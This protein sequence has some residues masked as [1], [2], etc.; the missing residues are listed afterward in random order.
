MRHS[1]RLSLGSIGMAALMLGVILSGCGASSITTVRQG[2]AVSTATATADI[3]F[4]TATTDPALVEMPGCPPVELGPVQSQYITVG[5][6]KVSI[7]HRYT[8]LD[9]PEEL[10]PNSEPNAPYRV[11][12]TASE[13]EQAGAFHPN[14]PVNPS[15][16]TG[17]V[18]QVCNQTG[19]SHTVTSLSI[20]IASFTPSSGP[21]TVWHI[22]QDGPYDAA[23]K[24]T[25]PGCGGAAGEVDWLAAT[26]PSD[27]TGATAS[28]TTNAQLHSSGPNLPIALGP[29]KSI[30][31][32]IA[33]NG[34]TSQG[35]YTL[36]FGISVDGAAPT[37]LA[38]S[39]GAFLMAPSATVWTGT[40][41]QT[42]AMQT[43]IPAASQ[44]TY[45]VCPPAA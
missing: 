9:Y 20:H 44:D 25:T 8:P 10:M 15:L 30:V 36:G 41:C 7:P 38:P 13:A 34:L 1:R 11:P 6:L 31:F 45:Y 4:P 2:A 33:V 3:P 5:G 42:P 26:L 16:S 37:K 23:T 39:D 19:A 24:Q 27:R 14:P 32:L 17:Y 18:L 22:C 29:N 40:A 35:M 21:I 28:A 12:L 43:H